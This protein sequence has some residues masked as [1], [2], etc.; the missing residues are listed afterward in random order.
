M[1]LDFLKKISNKI[2]QVAID[3]PSVSGKSS[4]AKEVAKHFKFNHINSG[5]IYR[6]ISYETMLRCDLT[7]LKSPKFDQGIVKQIIQNANIDII[8]N[9][10]KSSK[11]LNNPTVEEIKE[12]YNKFLDELK[13][14]N[15]NIDKDQKIYNNG[16]DVTET[17]LKESIGL[18]TSL[19][20]SIQEVRNRVNEI[21]IFYIN[22]SSQNGIVIDGRDISYNVLPNAEVKLFIT[23]SIEE[24]A[25]RSLRRSKE[26]TTDENISETVQKIAQRDHSDITRKHGPLKKTN[27]AI[28]V[29]TTELNYEESIK[30]TI[31]IVSKI[32][33]N[34]NLKSEIE[35]NKVE[36]KFLKFDFK[37]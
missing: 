11:P 28:V 20:A 4:M 7:F 31:E 13:K 36:N 26:N 19:L 27:D 17:L 33:K 24:R 29:D 18:A 9:K 30:K 37:K 12:S 34:Y 25:K 10:K 23:A 8:S 3:G 32:Y 35:R 14:M 5:L 22:E 16:E 15:V 1:K 21:Q 2:F 6:S